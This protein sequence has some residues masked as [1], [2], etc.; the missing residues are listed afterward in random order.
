MIC[1]KQPGKTPPEAPPKS[2]ETPKKIDEDC[3]TPKDPC[4]M[5]N[6]TIGLCDRIVVPPSPEAIS[7]IENWEYKLNS[8]SK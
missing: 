5:A 8:N 2:P 6:S 3:G 7:G 1:R 4:A